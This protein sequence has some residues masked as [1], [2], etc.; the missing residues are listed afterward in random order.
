MSETHAVCQDGAGERNRGQAIVELSVC[1]ER[2][3]PLRGSGLCVTML[4]GM[5]LIHNLWSDADSMYF[6]S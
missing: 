1:N 4:A 5:I 2:E 3:F 6:L